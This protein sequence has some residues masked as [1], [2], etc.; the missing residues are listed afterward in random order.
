MAACASLAKCWAG[1]GDSEKKYEIRFTKYETR[2]QKYEIR[3]MIY[4]IRNMKN[5][6]MCD[7]VNVKMCEY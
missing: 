7:F 5:V 3:D 6:K 4:E 1:P 2:N